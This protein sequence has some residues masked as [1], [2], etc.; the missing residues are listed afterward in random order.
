MRPQ[1]TGKNLGDET[2]RFKFRSDEEMQTIFQAI[3][4]E[5]RDAVDNVM[6]MYKD[7]VAPLINETSRELLGVDIANILNYLPMA[8]EGRARGDKRVL[9]LSQLG[10]KGRRFALDQ[11][12][13]ASFLQSRTGGS[14]SLYAMDF[15]EMID[16]NLTDVAEYVGM[17]EP[18]R[19]ATAILQPGELGSTYEELADILGKRRADRLWSWIGTL[20]DPSVKQSDTDRFLG[21]VSAVVRRGIL[22]LNISVSLSQVVSLNNIKNYLTEGGVRRDLLASVMGSDGTPLKAKY[23]RREM[24]GMHPTLRKRFEGVPEVGLKSE[25]EK[26][27]AQRRFGRHGGVAGQVASHALLLGETGIG[28][29]KKMDAWAV[30]KLIET[31]ERQAARHG[32]NQEEK[33]DKIITTL[34]RTQPTS[35]PLHTSYFIGSPSAGIKKFVFGVFQSARDNVRGELQ[36]NW[37][38]FRKAKHMKDDKGMRIAI[39][40]MF[41]TWVSG[42]AM[43]AVIQ[44]A[45][46]RLTS[47]GDDEEENPFLLDIALRTLMNVIGIVPIAGTIIA[48]AIDSALGNYTGDINSPMLQQLSKMMKMANLPEDEEEMDAYMLR[49]IKETAGMVGSG[50]K[51]VIRQAERLFTEED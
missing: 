17:A 24:A 19:T 38:A 1:G 20:E 49:L 14:N 10:N 48:G 43:V 16:R 32:W 50:W 29:V 33:W 18:I 15:F 9:H 11:I 45:V 42:A 34:N 40:N 41:R 2:A 31:I 23:S 7:E 3:P 21:K 4:Q 28:P 13:H 37:A 51:N 27:N 5:L 46:Q 44:E 35:D 47:G 25:G 36:T 26:A 22:K 6:A 39:Q 8:I 12:E 30:S